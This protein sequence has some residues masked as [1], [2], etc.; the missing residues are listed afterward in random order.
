LADDE[1]PETRRRDTRRRSF[2]PKLKGVKKILVVEDDPINGL[3][4][5][6]Y[7][8]ANGYQ[9]FLARNGTDGVA[10]FEKDQPDLMIVDV[11]LPYKNGFEVCFAVKR[12][13]G[14]EKTP[15][16][17]MSAVYKDKA[18]AEQYAKDGL[19]AQGF[20]MK[21]FE[22]SELLTRVRELVG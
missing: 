21:P 16:L 10:A 8:E 3:V 13:P 9:T 19:R 2:L 20:L 22:L 4:L 11:L 6:D 5:M 17:L 7:L 12:A 15:V 14:G 1:R 18:H